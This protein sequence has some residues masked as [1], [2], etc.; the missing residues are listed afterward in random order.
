L[1]TSRGLSVE[2]FPEPYSHEVSLSDY[3][4]LCTLP[5]PF[6][7]R[8]GLPKVGPPVS[9][10]PWTKGPQSGTK[11]Y[12]GETRGSTLG[13]AGPLGPRAHTP[14]PRGNFPTR[15]HKGE[16]PGRVGGG[17]DRAKKACIWPST[18][19]LLNS[20]LAT[21][22]AQLAYVRELE[23]GCDQGA[24]RQGILVRK[25]TALQKS[26]SSARVSPRPF[27]LGDPPP[28]NVRL[29]GRCFTHAGIDLTYET[30]LLPAKRE[31]PSFEATH[32]S[33]L[34]PAMSTGSMSKLH[35]ICWVFRY[36]QNLAP[37]TG[38]R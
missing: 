14:G 10:T 5:S 35:S 32:V 24:L 31:F 27:G 37:R 25:V 21:P 6:F 11:V 26:Y 38:F 1:A 15:S 9:P 28:V 30:H 16:E 20:P 29:R 4:V 36:P 34:S 2:L 8:L 7:Q 33:I 23:R 18:S 19:K 13:K 22:P 17:K 3:L 12:P